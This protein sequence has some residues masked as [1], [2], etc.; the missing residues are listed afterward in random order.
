M[1]RMMRI[2]AAAVAAAII[3]A[4]FPVTVPAAGPAGEVEKTVEVPATKPYS[5][6]V[7]QLAAAKDAPQMIIIISNP[8]DP[9]RGNLSWYRRDPSGKLVSVMN[10][11]CVTAM[12]GVVSPEEKAEGDM[13][14]PSGLYHFNGA[15]GLKM[16]PG[17]KIS[18]HQF[19]EGDYWVDDPKSAHY[20]KL[21]KIGSVQKDWDSAE[22]LMNAGIC[23]D[24][25]L[26]IDYN[27]ECTPGKGSA[28][29][30]HCPKAFNN[31][32]TSGCISIPEDKMETLLQNVTTQTKVIIV[33]TEEDL[34][35]Y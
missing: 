7:N 33:R 21:V 20:N 18:Y 35:G 3:T 12:E 2:A 17:S 34:A 22:D 16:N 19:A 5:G 31:T 9:A 30:L 15:Y 28:I 26:A 27:K 14:T 11:V 23:Y 8:D 29:F 32:G 25:V 13:R 24:Y 10:E 6:D 1:K 4:A